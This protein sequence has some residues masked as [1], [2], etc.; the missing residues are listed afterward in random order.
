[1]PSYLL[2]TTSERSLIYGLLN[3]IVLLAFYK[4]TDPVCA[5]RT[6]PLWSFTPTGEECSS[7][8]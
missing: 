1:R 4:N 8:S 6:S 2:E 7:G 5:L 3:P